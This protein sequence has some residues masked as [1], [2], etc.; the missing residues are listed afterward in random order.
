MWT[1][2]G[3]DL[4]ACDVL[5]GILKKAYEDIYSPL[6]AKIPRILMRGAGSFICRKKKRPIEAYLEMR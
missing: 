6:S 2:L 1:D 4:E 5:L 3:L